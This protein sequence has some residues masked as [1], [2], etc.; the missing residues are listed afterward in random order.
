MNKVVNIRLGHYVLTADEDAAIA[1]GQYTD[2]L[3]QKYAGEDGAA[4]IVGDIEERIGEL[5]DKKQKENNRSFTTLE[6]VKDVIAQMG[7]LDGASQEQTFTYNEPHRRL[8]R[9]PD[10]KILAGV[11]SGIGAYFDIDPVILRVGWAI[12]V[13]VFGFGIP[14]YIILWIV[15]P[16]ART[17]AEKLMMRGQRPTL[18]NIEDN[19]KSE[20]SEVKSRFKNTQTRS[21][22]AAFVQGIAKAIV[23]VVLFAVNV[24]MSVIGGLLIAC[25][26]ALLIA[27]FT[28]NIHA[29]FNNFILNGQS[30]LDILLNAGGNALAIKIALVSWLLLVIA[31]IAIAVFRNSRNRERMR[32]PRRY[33]SWATT[34]VFLILFAFVFDAARNFRNKTEKIMFQEMI[35]VSGDT[36]YLE[37]TEL[38]TEKSGLFTLNYLE[39][40]EQSDDSFFHIEQHNKIFGPRKYYGA[41]NHSNFPKTYSIR[42]NTLNLQPGTDVKNL[43]NSEL[44][45]VKYTIYVPKGKWVKCKKNMYFS[46]NNYANLFAFGDAVFMDSTGTGIYNGRSGQTKRLDN[47][48]ERIKIS[49]KF[50][51]QIIPSGSNKLELVSGPILNHPDWIETDGNSLEIDEDFGDFLDKTSVIRIYL[52][53]LQKIEANGVAE[54]HFKNWKSENLDIECTGATKI[55]GTVRIHQLNLDLEGASRSELKGKVESLN[56]DISGASDYSSL[57]LESNRADV[58]ASGASSVKVWTTESI[59]ARISGGSSLKLKGDPQESN[60]DNSG[61][62]SYEHIK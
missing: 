2:A 12:S 1:A 23:A 56:L 38:N 8:Y 36:L 7:P 15:M 60:I 45:W 43:E 54:I 35:P 53:D 14:L 39:D 31:V 32:M 62:A 22:F 29:E 57:D 16:E 34:I 40:I 42:N 30:G 58:H 25:L 20:F 24:A 18:Q 13:F 59:H 48:L 46:E 55:M 10:N 49:G 52:K 50:N 6:D 27:F 37:S 26:I 33:L 11:W 19:I 51:V 21:R 17:T 28:D 4:E 44:N 5:L 47:Q 61:A 41:P 9:D 3:H